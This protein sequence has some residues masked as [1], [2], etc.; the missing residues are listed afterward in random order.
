MG[1]CSM[2]YM[3]FR[4]CGS[5]IIHV[6]SPA[7]RREGDNAAGQGGGAAKGIVSI[8]TV[9]TINNIFE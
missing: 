9:V 8:V 6:Q 2:I 4:P 7:K 1:K 3:K 5:W